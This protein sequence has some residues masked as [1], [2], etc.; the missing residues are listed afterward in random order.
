MSRAFPGEWKKWEMNSEPWSEV[1]W[2]GTPCL[3][4]TWKRKSFANSGD[5]TLLLVGMNMHCFDSWSTTIRIA[6]YPEEL[7]SCSMKSIEMEFHGF[8]GIGSCLSKP[9]GLNLGTFMHAQVVQEETYSLMNVL[10]PGQVYLWQMSSKVQFCPKCPESGLS[11]LYLSRL[12]QLWNYLQNI[13]R[14]VSDG[15]W[16]QW[17]GEEHCTLVNSV[18]KSSLVRFFCYFWKDQT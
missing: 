2:K 10:T 7:G 17:L 4:K 9:K 16:L 15:T 6:V 18:W 5:V 11:C 1:M 12:G 13:W 8:S 3:E 14:L